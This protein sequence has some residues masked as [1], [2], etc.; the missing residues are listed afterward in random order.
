VLK[1][2]DHLTDKVDLL[3]PVEAPISKMKG[4]FRWHLFLKTFSP[5][6]HTQVLR[7]IQGIVNRFLKTKAVTLTWDVDPYYML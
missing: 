6:V 5:Y 1:K 2:D 3:G 7:N 4:K